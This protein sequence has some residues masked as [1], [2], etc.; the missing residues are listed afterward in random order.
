MLTL[1]DAMRELAATT[2]ARPQLLRSTMAGR[3]G[4]TLLHVSSPK[5]CFKFAVRAPCWLHS[6]LVTVATHSSIILSTIQSKCPPLT[7][8]TCRF[9]RYKALISSC[10]TPHWGLHIPWQN[11]SQFSKNCQRPFPKPVEL[12]LEKHAHPRDVKQRIS[13]LHHSDGY[14]LLCRLGHSTYP[15]LH[16]PSNK[17]DNCQLCNDQAHKMRGQRVHVKMLFIA[18]YLWGN[19]YWKQLKWLVKLQAWNKLHNLL[20]FF[21]CPRNSFQKLHIGRNA[22][23][24]QK[25]C[26]NG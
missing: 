1:W 9:W 16:S 26:N 23:I 15:Q 12:G 5:A 6:I 3:L 4:A 22:I 14:E 11:L 18:H 10:Q 8:L 25:L 2:L 24:V 19:Q 20:I 21:F 7:I 17:S 13:L